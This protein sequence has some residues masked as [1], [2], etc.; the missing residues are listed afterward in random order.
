MQN[1]IRIVIALLIV[2]GITACAT[3][4]QPQGATGGYSEIKI[5]NDL[6]TVRFGGNGN[7]SKNTVFKYWLYR[8]AELTQQNGYA[9]FE[10]LGRASGNTNITRDDAVASH[11]MQPVMEPI[12]GHLG[13]NESIKTKGGGYVPVY[14]P[15]YSYTTVTTWSMNSTIRMSK[16]VPAEEHPTIYKAANILKELA[17][18][19]L[20][21]IPLTDDILKKKYDAELSMASW[22]TARPR[23]VVPRLDDG[24]NL[25]D[26]K[27]LIPLNKQK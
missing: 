26:L 16:Q 22:M 20:H 3:P 24:S 9:Y 18:E 11:V 12:A 1:T 10:V 6:Y 8:C 15:S 14:I 13:D 21:Q 19:V 5:A 7:T 17:N 23:P 4:Y 2:A 27:N 25:D